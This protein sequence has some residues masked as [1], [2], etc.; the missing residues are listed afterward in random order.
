MS[1]KLKDIYKYSVI[2]LI[3]CMLSFQDYSTLYF[4]LTVISFGLCM[5]CQIKN[6]NIVFDKKNTK[7]ILNKII[8][9]F[10]CFFISSFSEYSANSNKVIVGIIVR[11]IN[12]ITVL[13]YIDDEEKANKITKIILYSSVILCIRLIINVPFS[14]F[15]RERIGI[16]LAHNPGNSYGYTG[17]TYVLGF[18]VIILLTKQNILNNNVFKW[19][20][21]IIFIIF[22]LLSGSKKQIF[23]III[24]MMCIIIYN[25]NNIKKFIVNISVSIVFFIVLIYFIFS[26]E[27][28]YNAIGIRLKGMQNYFSSDSANSG[29]LSTIGRANFLKEAKR[30]FRENYIKGVGIDNFKFYN[31]YSLCWAE[32]NYWELL[33]DT[34]VIGFLIFYYIYLVFVIDIIKRRRKKGSNDLT[35]FSVIMCYLFVDYTMVTYSVISLQFYF[36]YCYS[37]N[38]I[39]MQKYV[40]ENNKCN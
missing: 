2:G 16:Y 40:K 13:L 22:S 25:K 14:A 37:L 11:I 26:N 9:V 28:L 4:C 34:G 7:F 29:D 20:L 1:L 36:I 10:Y 24:T 31:N 8:F 39:E 5:L 18:S 6:N 33:A 27:Y 21:A 15:G 12:S 17:I 23:M 30:V 3:V 38:K 19:V 35:I 32:N